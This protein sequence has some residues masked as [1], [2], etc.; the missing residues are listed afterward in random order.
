M[1]KSFVMGHSK[2]RLS[3]PSSLDFPKEKGL[4]EEY[5]RES[6][7]KYLKNQELPMVNEERF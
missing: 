6:K 1:N 2:N 7:T 4:F 3:P 5:F